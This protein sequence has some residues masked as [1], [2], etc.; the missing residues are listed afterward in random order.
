M[1]EKLV[2]KM[3]IGWYWK[4][5]KQIESGTGRKRE[6]KQINKNILYKPNFT[7]NL[8]WLHK[9][10]TPFLYDSYVYIY[11]PTHPI[12]LMTICHSKIPFNPI[13]FHR[14]FY[15]SSRY[16]T[17]IEANIIFAENPCTMEETMPWR[18]H[19]I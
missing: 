19:S 1:R 4:W 7:H 3:A 9:P 2:E 14:L 16:R 10:T 15:F 12:T 6:R 17:I 5:D 13:N 18:L 11:S 8:F